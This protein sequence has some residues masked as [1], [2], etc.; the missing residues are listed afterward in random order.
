MRANVRAGVRANVRAHRNSIHQ[1]HSLVVYCSCLP[2]YPPS[3]SIVSVCLT[4]YLVS[5]SVG[6]SAVL[7]HLCL[8]DIARQ[9]S[10]CLSFDSRCHAPFFLEACHLN[11]ERGWQSAQWPPLSDAAAAQLQPRSL[12]GTTPPPHLSLSPSLRDS[13]YTFT[14]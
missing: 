8:F 4:V 1:R 3:F 14:W 10:L 7:P 11:V 5:L 13:Q 6:L 9:L 2:T 12:R